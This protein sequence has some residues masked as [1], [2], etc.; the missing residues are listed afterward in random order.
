MGQNFL[1]QPKLAVMVRRCLENKAP[2]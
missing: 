1:T 2:K